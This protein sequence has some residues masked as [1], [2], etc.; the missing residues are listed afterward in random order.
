MSLMII[1]DE[2]SPEPVQPQKED[3]SENTEKASAD[4]TDHPDQEE[5][6]I[7]SNNTDHK[8]DTPENMDETKGAGQRN[9]R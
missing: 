7:Q 1:E 4:M 9:N 2:S 5:N 3:L 6:Q 8:T